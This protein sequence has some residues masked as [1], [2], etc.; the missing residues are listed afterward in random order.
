[1]SYMAKLSD[2]MLMADVIAWQPI[3]EKDKVVLTSISILV[4]M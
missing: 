1:M 4:L 2:L 3:T